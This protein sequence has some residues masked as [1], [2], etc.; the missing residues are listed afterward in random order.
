MLHQSHEVTSAI[1]MNF[2][3][4]DRQLAERND[5]LLR[6]GLCREHHTTTPEAQAAMLYGVGDLIGATKDRV[7]E[8]QD[9]ALMKLRGLLA[10]PRDA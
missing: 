8:I 10:K 2:I 6:F 3:T 9:K 5:V 4:A 7:R 1:P